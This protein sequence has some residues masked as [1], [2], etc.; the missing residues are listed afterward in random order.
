M[1]PWSCPACG[2]EF[3]RQRSHVCAPALS[4]GQ[5]FAARPDVE[6][7]IFEKVREHLVSL[8]P[9]IVEPVN[10]GIFVKGQRNFVELR[11]KAKS[12]ALSF[13]LNRLVQHPR[14]ARTVKTKTSRTC[15]GLN[16]TSPADVDQQVLDWLTESYFEVSR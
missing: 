9:V 7:E 2:R 14:I 11:P 5:Y 16:I 12:V 15:H 4:I 13:A 6:R 3:A 8:G 1:Q 10:V